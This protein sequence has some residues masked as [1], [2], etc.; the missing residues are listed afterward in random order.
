MKTTA[1]SFILLALPAFLFADDKK[2]PELVKVYCFSEAMEAGFVDKGI[3]F[4]KE[5]NKRG[6]KKK[7]LVRVESRDEVHMLVEFLSAETVTTRGETTYVSSGM[8]WTPESKKNI[9]RARVM[10]GDFS[11]EFSSKGI[12]AQAMAG[13]VHQVE[14]WIRE[15]RENILE[16]ASTQAQAQQ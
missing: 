16:K 11:K 6:T 3:G 10:V 13:L 4:C 8:A 15:N 1:I 2:D 14:K 7:S 5:I 12:N 9:R